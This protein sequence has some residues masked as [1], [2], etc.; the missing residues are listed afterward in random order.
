MLSVAQQQMVEIA[1]AL[2]LN[3]RLIIMDEPS[4]ALSDSE[5]ESL[6]RVVRELKNRGVSII[7]VTHRLHEVFQL[8]D[9]FTVFQ[10]GRF[11]GTGAVAE[12]NVEQLIRLMVG[13]DVAFNRRPAS[14]THHQD[15]PVRLAVKGLSR[16]KPPLDSARHR[17]AR[18][19]LPRPRRGSSGHCRAGGRGTHRG[20]PLPV[21]RRRLYLR[22]L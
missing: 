17:P 4:A 20:G 19:Q 9:R 10:D 3:A 18:H 2:T 11:T 1:R 5:V 7:Y 12:T 16:E 21:W 15:K 8:C 13:R 22:E 6:H 14:E